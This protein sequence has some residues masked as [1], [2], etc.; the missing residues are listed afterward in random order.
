MEKGTPRLPNSVVD[1][2][3][4]SFDSAAVMTDPVHGDQ[5]VAFVMKKL[6]WIV[7]GD[8]PM[9]EMFAPDGTGAGD[10][11]S[12]DVTA[13][14]AE[15][16]AEKKDAEVE[17]DLIDEVAASHNACKSFFLNCIIGCF[18]EFGMCL[19]LTYDVYQDVCNPS[20]SFVTRPSVNLDTLRT[21]AIT[22]LTLA[23]D[24]PAVLAAV[25]DQGRNASSSLLLSHFFRSVYF[26][27]AGVRIPMT[28]RAE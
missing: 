6:V 1:E 21:A 17:V 22:A 4:V 18:P 8:T 3:D 26:H 11:A 15:K 28:M 16:E 14:T 5:F 20:P 2:D 10:T 7:D 27:D 13:Q 24:L 19:Q 9:M 23:S 12:I 25:T